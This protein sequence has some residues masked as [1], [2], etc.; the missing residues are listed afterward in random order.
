MMAA[1]ALVGKAGYSTVAEAY[2]AGIPYGYITRPASP[3]SAVLEDFIT[4]HL[5]ARSISAEA[6]HNG[7]WTEALAELLKLDKTEPPGENGADQAASY[8]YRIM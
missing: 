7:R 8:I 4:R 6:Y 1:D 3:E 5:P 2:Q